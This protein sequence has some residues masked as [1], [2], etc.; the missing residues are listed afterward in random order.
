MADYGTYSTQ[1]DFV[2]SLVDFSTHELGGFQEDLMVATT[3]ANAL[4]GVFAL[5]YVANIVWKSWV[6]GGQIDLYKCFRP[7]VIGF[8]IVNYPRT[9]DSWASDFIADCLRVGLTSAPSV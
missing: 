2:D 9:K 4:C 6:S 7:F 5:F 1:M 3:Y 8:L